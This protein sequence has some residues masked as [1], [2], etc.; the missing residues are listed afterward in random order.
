MHENVQRLKLLQNK[1]KEIID[2]KQLKTIPQIVAVTKTWPISKIIPLLEM[3]HIH[4]GE[5]KIQEAE[6][7]WLDIKNKYNHLQLHMLGKLQSNKT[8]KAVKLFDY[9]HSLDN[10]KLAKKI[11]QHEKE[12]NKKIKLFIQ[13]NLSADNLKSGILLNDLKNFYNYC[14]TELSL[15]IIGLMCLPPINSDSNK[16]FKI[17]KKTSEELNLKQLSM[18]MSEDY[19]QAILNRSTF[20]RLGTV[21]LGK[22]SI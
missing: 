16:Y 10:I 14:V 18:G 12:L 21:I 22:R 13:V 4:F 15:N 8:K 1:I 7:K 9:I 19:E 20:L 3:G 11:S 17:T 2:K 5:N 6:I